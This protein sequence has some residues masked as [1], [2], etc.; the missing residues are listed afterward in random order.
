MIKLKKTVCAALAAACL[1]TAMPQ[2]LAYTDI[3]A[4]AACLEAV[5]R[6]GDL[7]I[8]SGYSD[9]SFHPEATITRA[10]FARII[11]S[12]L[13]KDTEA[14]SAGFVSSF[15]DVSAGLWSAPYINYVS[16]QNIVAGY[17]D[18]SFCPDKTISFAES[19]TIMMR[20]LGYT[21]D[22]V[23]YFWPNNYVDAANS[24]GISSDMA[25]GVNQPIT[26]GDAAIMLDRVLFTDMNGKTDVPLISTGSSRS[27]L[28]DMIVLESGAQSSKLL[29]KEVKLSDSKVY[30]S[31]MSTAAYSGTFADYA[32]LDKGGNLVA[33]KETGEGANKAANS[34]AVYVNSVTDNTVNYVTNGQTGSYRF[35][36]S[37]EI[38]TS[39]GKTTFAQAKSM[40][41]AG[42]DL[43][44]YGEV[45]GSWSFAVVGSDN[46]IEPVI[47]RHN[48]STSDTNMEG[49]AIN[50]AGLVVYRDAKSASISDI[51][52][53]DVVYYNT[54]TNVMDVYSKKVTGIYYDA[55]PSKA[56][57]E[58]VTVGGKSY[59]L[60]NDAAANS[61]GAGTGSFDIGD[62]VTLLLGK[63]D[64]AVFAVELSDTAI[65]DYGVVLSVGTRIAESGDNEGSGERY[66]DVFMTDGEM[67]RIV[68]D[69]KY[70]YT[71]GQ[72]VKI[73]YQNGK[74]HLATQSRPDNAS[75]TLD[76]ANR[77]LNGKSILKDA[78]IIQRTYYSAENEARCELLQLETM[79]AGEI[80]DSQ[81]LNIISGSAFGD[82]S[83]IY[84]KDL[85]ATADFGIVSAVTK[86]HDD[87][88]T[89]YEIF[90]GDG[91]TSYDTSM[92]SAGLSVGMPVMYEIE[93]GRIDTIKQ[94]YKLATGSI[95]AVDASRI[96]IG[97][98]IYELSP[99]VLIATGANSDYSA[100]S[101][102]DLEDG[103]Y[104]N[105]TI[106]SDTSKNSGCLVRVI[107]VR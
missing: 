89:G 105:A 27:V 103:K 85:E 33:L 99:E 41:K 94:L 55:Q 82:I 79:A 11:V 24:L 23:G 66:A 43:T 5:T 22:T 101:I 40:I 46:D 64:K 76:K 28:R 3:A 93:G 9:G 86:S 21:E 65:G 2:S 39:D 47:A 7:G 38:Y 13:D 96:K 74:A 104:S 97:G 35:D 62:R 77:T 18:G 61:L 87:S 6:L 8:I 34:M 100:V 107:I 17:S 106:Y 92:V 78:V 32:V 70:E 42:T 60:G 91:K 84:V 19:L 58:S 102:D 37:F 15:A 36:G 95:N 52:T 49:V 72:L 12:A 71:I 75:G 25:Y 69:S 80:N 31:K 30:T 63:N 56:Y 90:S 83:I 57:V 51:K 16:A 45:S 88:V 26:R 54:R 53:N 48:Y 44:F 50:S 68:T 10:E 67:H 4:D 98:T 14:K 59:E 1:L 29:P 20:I 73:T 81:L